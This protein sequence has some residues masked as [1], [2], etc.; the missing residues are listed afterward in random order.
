[1]PWTARHAEHVADCGDDRHAGRQCDRDVVLWC[2]RDVGAKLF[3]V[4]HAF[5]GF[6][7]LYIV[8]TIPKGN[9]SFFFTDT[10]WKYSC[11]EDHV[12]LCEFAFGAAFH[13]RPWIPND[14]A[15][16]GS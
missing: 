5:S 6:T 16:G 3:A 2:C 15:H 9:C 11:G 14:I 13:R 4:K 7:R 1:M 12:E 8:N 10:D